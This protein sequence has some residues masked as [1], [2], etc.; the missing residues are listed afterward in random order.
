MSSPMP[1]MRSP[2]CT[3]V[4]MT[5]AGILPLAAASAEDQPQ[6][7]P[8]YV[9]NESPF[10]FLGVRHATIRVSALKFLTGMNS[11][12]M[13]QI[14]ELDPLSPGIAA[15]VKAGDRI[16]SIDGVSITKFGIH[17]LRRMGDEVV[18]GQKIVVD[19]MRPSDA[20]VRTMVVVVARK[21]KIPS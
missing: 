20:S 13:L 18:A 2:A 14:D 1:S 17:K 6:T 12:T 16:I 21:P 8:A 3:F 11:V 10:G 4:L 15:G 7:G 19:V 5:L 9:V